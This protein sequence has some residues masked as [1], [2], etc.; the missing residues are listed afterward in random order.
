MSCDR[1]ED[2]NKG[3]GVIFV[4]NDFI[5]DTP[6]GLRIGQH[7]KLGY[8]VIQSAR[9][10]IKSKFHPGMKLCAIG[11][12]DCQGMGVADVKEALAT[13]PRPVSVTACLNDMSA[14][15]GR[16]G[17]GKMGELQIQAVLDAFIREVRVLRHEKKHLDHE[18]K[19]HHE[20]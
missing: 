14:L 20:L 3:K 11:T 13:A 16:D 7:P 19:V 6:I 15:C 8:A 9:G 10:D 17:G 4:Q 2:V 5:K 12:M 18:L 1:F